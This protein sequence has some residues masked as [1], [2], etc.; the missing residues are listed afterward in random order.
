[1][2]DVAVRFLI[3]PVWNSHERTPM[4]DASLMAN[5]TLASSS[6]LFCCNNSAKC[7]FNILTS[8]HHLTVVGISGS[9]Y[10]VF[11]SWGRNTTLMATASCSD[12]LILVLWSDSLSLWQPIDWVFRVNCCSSCLNNRKHEQT[13]IGR[14]EAKVMAKIAQDKE[15]ELNRSPE[16]L[17][18]FLMN[19]TSCIPSNRLTLIIRVF[20]FGF[21][22]R[23]TAFLTLHKVA[24]IPGNV[25][26]WTKSGPTW[27]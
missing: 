22:Y 25:E 13:N 23:M 11:F 8:I 1:M 3:T 4:N 21:N 20:G 9:L 6:A 14:F 27:G 7:M 2:G 12:A 10:V 15:I 24:R 17:H 19:Q 5:M 26:C 18:L 16:T